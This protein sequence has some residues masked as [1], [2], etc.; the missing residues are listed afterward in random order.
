MRAAEESLWR[1]RSRA[2]MRGEWRIPFEFMSTRSSPRVMLQFRNY[3]LESSTDPG[4]ESLCENSKLERFCSARLQGGTLKS[5]R[6]PPEGGRYNNHNRV[7]AQTLR[8]RVTA[9]GQATE[10]CCSPPLQRRGFCD[11]AQQNL[12][13]NSTTIRERALRKLW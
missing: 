7:L 8:T 10:I 9:F 3:P 2:D 4:L 12:E 11:S 13:I 6:C 1:P 5:S